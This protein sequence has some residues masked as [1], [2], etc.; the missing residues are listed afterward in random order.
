[1]DRNYHTPAGSHARTEPVLRDDYPLPCELRC[2]NQRAIDIAGLFGEL[3]RRTKATRGLSP[4]SERAESGAGQ[5][6]GRRTG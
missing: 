6:G 4:E 2:P 1:M 5:S 3:C